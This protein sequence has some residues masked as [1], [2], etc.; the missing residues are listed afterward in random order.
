MEKT[1]ALLITCGVV[2]GIGIQAAIAWFQPEKLI[3][4]DL[5]IIDYNQKYA[6]GF[7]QLLSPATRRKMV[8]SRLYPWY[9]RIV[10]TA[11]TIFFFLAFMSIWL[12]P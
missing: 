1:F 3:E 6:P 9:L 4:R 5:R 2:V 11:V 10:L 7:P 12:K 8:R